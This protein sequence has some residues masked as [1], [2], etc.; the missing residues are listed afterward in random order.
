M[1]QNHS[2]MYSTL[3]KLCRFIIKLLGWK[4]DAI[5]PKHQKYVL[6]G[7]PHEKT[8]DF[9]MFILF[10]CALQLPARWM[11]K[12]TIFIWPVRGLLLWL[13]GIPIDRRSP[14]NK[15][16]QVADMIQDIDRIALVITPEG[17]R[18][19]VKR[20]KTGFYYIAQEAKIPIVMGYLDY[21]HKKAGLIGDYIPTGEVNS[22]ITE[23]QQMYEAVLNRKVI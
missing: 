12:H 9:F 11:A 7:A 3:G 5:A 6:I 2:W 1:L 20:W 22:D 4:L 13:G 8:R 18:S 19:K 14:H 15:V 17:T 23:M 10:M 21:P 16:K